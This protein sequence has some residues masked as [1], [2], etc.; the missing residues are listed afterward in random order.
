MRSIVVLALLAL[1]AAAPAHADAP[2]TS[3]ALA[4]HLASRAHDRAIRADVL[5]WHHTMTNG[6]VAY[7]STALRHVGVAIGEREVLDGDGVSR[8]TRGFVRYLE[9]TL[10]FT[11]LTDPRALAP[12]DLARIVHQDVERGQAMRGGSRRTPEAQRGVG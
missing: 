2:S 6:C 9:D 3:A 10:G 7:A 5:G 12:G 4:S 1:L 11:R 8:L